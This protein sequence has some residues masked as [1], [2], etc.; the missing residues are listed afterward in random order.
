MAKKDVLKVNEAKRIV[1]SDTGYRL[2]LHGVTE[3]DLSGNYVRLLCNE[4]YVLI[5]PDKVFA[6]IITGEK[7][8]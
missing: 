8:A 5:N 1:V 7:V 3:V 4:G 2:S 6:H